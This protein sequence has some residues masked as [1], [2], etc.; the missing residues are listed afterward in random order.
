MSAARIF[1]FILGTIV[2]VAL[3]VGLVP[4]AGITRDK[5]LPPAVGYGEA[6]K[7]ARGVITRK[8]ATPTANPFKVG[9]H[10]FMFDYQFVAP[11]PDAMQAGRPNATETY[12]GALRIEQNIYGD[13]STGKGGVYEGM[14]LRVK[15]DPAYPWINGID[16]DW[17]GRS[18]GEGSNILSGWLIWV[19]VALI[20]G[21]LFMML[22]ERFAKTENI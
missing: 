1:R 14:P 21:Y 7:L 19:V 17:G 18:V 15:Y 10:I 12:K 20:L 3:L 8:Y 11:S 5:L 16:A 9:D 6:N 13:E 4:L 22:F 2:A